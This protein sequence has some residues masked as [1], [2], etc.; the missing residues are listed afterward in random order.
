MSRSDGARTSSVS[1]LALRRSSIPVSAHR[2]SPAHQRSPQSAATRS[3]NVRP[4]SAAM[5]DRSSLTR[6]ASRDRRGGAEGP[7]RGSP[8]PRPR[9]IGAKSPCLKRLHA[10]AARWTVRKL[11]R[12]TGRRS[13][14]ALKRGARS[15]GKDRASRRLSGCGSS[16]VS[17]R[18]QRS[19]G[20]VTTSAASPTRAKDYSPRHRVAVQDT[21]NRLVA[22]GMERPAKWWIAAERTA[23]AATGATAHP[24]ANTRTWPTVIRCSGHRRRR[25]DRPVRKRIGLTLYLTTRH[26]PFPF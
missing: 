5:Q 14:S 10:R 18:F 17:R 23:Y 2:R 24:R 16:E 15:V 7:R 19:S 12:L 8:R 25:P 26:L 9:P 6:I 20:S 4:G 11:R 22:E 21:G 3:S 1:P 13:Q